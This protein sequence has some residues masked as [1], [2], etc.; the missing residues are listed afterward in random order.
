MKLQLLFF[1]LLFPCVFFGQNNTGSA[2]STQ[3]DSLVNIFN[4]L[5]DTFYFAVRD[6]KETYLSK[7]EWEKEP[8]ATRDMFALSMYHPYR[9]KLFVGVYN[10]VQLVCTIPGCEQP[11]ITISKGL[12]IKIGENSYRAVVGFEPDVEIK[13]FIDGGDGSPKLVAQKKFT[14]LNLSPK[15]KRAV[16][17]DAGLPVEN[18]GSEIVAQPEI[19]PKYKEN[20]QALMI[21]ALKYPLAAWRK[22]VQGRVS[23][24]F[25]LN[26]GGFVKE[27]E[28]DDQ[29]PVK[30]PELFEELKRLL[31]LSSGKWFPALHRGLPV[32]VWQ[33]LTVKFTIVNTVPGITVE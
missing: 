2:S 13:V 12:I 26:A 18:R 7:E 29:S 25:L 11:M 6:N 14:V 27:V 9:D 4:N 15:L 22:D 10:P 23:V 32:D 30:H 20:L 33:N 8:V 19:P 16:L 5:R 21:E 31:F 28:P 24:R 17:T 3:P 1:S